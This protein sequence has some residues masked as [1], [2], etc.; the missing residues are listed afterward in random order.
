MKKLKNITIDSSTNNPLDSNEL[1]QCL[2]NN[3]KDKGNKISF[4]LQQIVILNLLIIS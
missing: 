2:R 4:S 1:D 3:K